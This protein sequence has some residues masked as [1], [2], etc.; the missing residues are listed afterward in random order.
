[1][2]K[3]VPEKKENNLEGVVDFLR[4]IAIAACAG[5]IFYAVARDSNEKPNATTGKTI[6]LENMTCVKKSW[7]GS[8]HYCKFGRAVPLTN[9][10]RNGA[11]EHYDLGPEPKK[12]SN[13]FS[14]IIDPNKI[15]QGKCYTIQIGD[16]DG[17]GRVVYSE[18]EK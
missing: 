14:A 7:D 13:K 10:D 15:E 1:M 3:S 11:S 17:E 6:T 2:L 16:L 8:N 9:A 18:L 5:M 4:F 12:Y